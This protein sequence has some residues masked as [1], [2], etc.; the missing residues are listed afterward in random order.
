MKTILSV[1]NR[2][3]RSIAILIS[4]FVFSS[5]T[6]SQIP[7][8]GLQLWLKSDTGVILNG[9]SV[10][11]WQDQSGN[12]NDAIQPNVNRQ[13]LFVDNELN[14]KP[15][16]RFDGSNDKL[17][18]TGSTPMTQISFF[19]VIKQ[20]Q[21]VRNPDEE[22]P[23]TFGGTDMT[24]GKQYFFVTRNPSVSDPDNRI[25]VGFDPT[26]SAEASANNIAAYDEWKNYSIVT[27]QT[28]WNTT[29]RWN[30]NDA[31]IAHIGSD[32]PLS[33]PLGNSLGTGGG[34]G[35]AD[36]VPEGTIAAKCDIA[37]LI[38][39]NRAVSDSERSVIATYLST[40]YNI[41]TTVDN[42]IFVDPNN[43]DFGDVLI[44][45]SSNPK[46]VLITN[47]GSELYTLN[48]IMVSNSSYELSDLPSFPK[49]V[50]PGDSIIF[51][52]SYV[53]D[54][55]GIE[56][57][58]ITIS[59]N[60][61]PD[62]KILLTGNGLLFG[63][64]FH[65]FYDRVIN[66]PYLQ[67]VA[68]VDSFMNINSVMP[69]IEQDSICQF[70]YRGNATS[71]SVS[72]DAEG[73]SAN[74]SPMHSLS[75]TNL[76]YRSEVFEPDARL[77]YKFI[78]D[79]TSW[80]TDPLNPRIVGGYENSELRMP[81]Y[82]Q[83]PELLYYS[84][85]P[86]GTLQDT[87]FFSTNLGNSRTVRIYLPPGYSLSKNYPVV[88]FHDGLQFI[89]EANAN[90]V[91]DYLISQNRI[92]PLI[93]V[94]VPPVNRDE[95]YVGSLQNQ[96][97][98][99][100]AEELMPYID[101]NYRTILNPGKRATI[102]I[103]NG[104]NIALWIVYNY[105]DVFGLAGS[106]SGNIQFTT[107]SAFQ[108]GTEHS[109]KIYLDAGKYDLPGF[110]TLTQDL[111]DVIQAK[112]YDFNYN[113]WNEGHSWLNWGAHL[114]NALEFFF[115]GSAVIVQEE[116]AVPNSFELMQNYPNPFNPSTTINFVIPKS[117]FVNL[118]VYDILGRE[119]AT[120]VNE[121][122]PAGSYELKWDAASLPSGIYFY[123]IQ[124]GSFAQT[125][126]MI[127]LK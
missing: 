94:F 83:P 44:G 85:I 23:V 75:S 28:I 11:T 90:N 3:C 59:T 104:G 16:L 58:E 61:N 115:P 103:S 26:H 14:G 27:D 56:N 70:I 95:E 38:V 29:I 74:G 47:K 124:A 32:A 82:I 42:N 108:S 114:D 73:W 96:F 127:L 39:Y 7:T 36:N 99:F 2:N 101:A 49:E 10:S 33:A 109:S 37:E 88:V 12:G 125:K 46:P 52:V 93:G 87:T 5:A 117:S 91:L 15:I 13:P 62:I 123:K 107:L 8:N 9:S 66:A 120:L 68:I 100:I 35:G 40:K 64:Q 119:V 4:L 80:I 97:A 51:K 77:E 45:N 126:K 34:I 43:V 30:G 53:P 105:P 118:K 18:F 89:T 1:F 50:P 121:E 54:I 92:Q 31:A 17:G 122:K 21:G 84:D 116:Q 65:A 111:R 110:L 79:G 76:W 24:S 113:E 6:F 78:I 41:V 102:G 72:G 60:S 22:I 69:F 112:G 106:N 19:I 67:R 71:V 55:H 98:S 25:D 86:H 57:G 48:S 20:Y 81:G 63:N